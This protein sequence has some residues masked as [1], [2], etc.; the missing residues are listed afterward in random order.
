MKVLRGRSSAPV[1]GPDEG[2]LSK[3]DAIM[4][5]LVEFPFA[6]NAVAMRTRKGL[7]KHGARSWRSPEY[8]RGL[9]YFTGKIGRHIL[10]IL[11]QRVNGESEL[12]HA[13]AMAWSAMAL[14]DTVLHAHAQRAGMG[15][16]PVRFAVHAYGE[17]EPSDE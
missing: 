7:D 2:T 3:P 6:A 4:D 16:D 11:G 9:R 12:D 8:T 15:G 14:A 1:S 5:C 13:A 17:G 10:A